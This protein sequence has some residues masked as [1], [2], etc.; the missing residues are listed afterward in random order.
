MLTCIQPSSSSIGGFG[1]A[2]DNVRILLMASVRNEFG[3]TSI[4]SRLGVTALGQHYVLVTKKKM[5][6]GYTT[7]MITANMRN[8]PFIS[9]PF[10][11]SSGAQSIEESRDL[12]SRL[13]TVLGRPGMFSF[14][15]P[16]IG[17]QFPVGKELIQLDEVPVGVHDRQDK[18]LEKGDEVFCEVNVSGVKF[19]HSGIYAGDG[20]CYHFVC[21]AQSESFADALAV[22]S[23]ASA[24][25][26]YDTWFEFVYAL[27]E[28]SDVPPKIFRASHPLI[29][30]SGEQVVKYAEHL[31]REL[32]NYDIRRCN[33]QHFSSECSTGVPFSYDMTSNFKYLACTVLKPTSTVVN[34]MTRPNRD[35]SSF[36]SSSTSS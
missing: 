27:V 33:C 5:F 22:F 20:M 9:I 34:A 24:H 15:D 8:R 17:S 25:V 3:D 30:R 28:V 2:D 19:Y 14:D 10:K 1:K 21:D 35:R 6:G 12:I 36:A 13:T 32:E 11:V 29:C 26:V 4:F 18:Y 31:Q 7:H 23:G 16:P